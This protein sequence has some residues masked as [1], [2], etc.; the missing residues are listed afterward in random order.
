MT[1]WNKLISQA[2]ENQK[3]TPLAKANASGYG[4][5]KEYNAAGGESAPQKEPIVTRGDIA[6]QQQAQQPEAPSDTLIVKADTT[7]EISN[8]QAA[9]IKNIAESKS[10]PS[11][12][13]T[14]NYLSPQPE[15]KLS[16]LDKAGNWY[17]EKIVKP[18]STIYL[19]KKA[20]QEINTYEEK[21]QAY[22]EQN[23][24]IKIAV[25]NYIS[26]QFTKEYVGALESG[27]TK[28]AAD[29]KNFYEGKGYELTVQKQGDTTYFS[30]INP[31][32]DREIASYS[33]LR[34]PEEIKYSAG[35]LRVGLATFTGS[36]VSIPLL[37][38]PKGQQEF[39]PGIVE[40]VYN[41]PKGIYEAG[42]QRSYGKLAIVGAEVGGTVAAAFFLGEAFN[43]GGSS[44]RYG[45][46]RMGL[47]DVKV[48]KINALSYSKE[49]P[50]P[51]ADVRM[52]KGNIAAE[53]SIKNL[54]GGTKK[55]YVS[56]ENIGFVSRDLIPTNLLGEIPAYEGF[57]PKGLSEAYKVD[58]LSKVKY[59]KV[60]GVGL[61]EGLS[62]DLSNF[63]RENFYYSTGKASIKTGKNILTRELTP[64]EVNLGLTKENI[65]D[66]GIS[67]DIP[68]PELIKNV[69]GVKAQNF[70]YRELSQNIGEPV[71]LGRFNRISTATIGET[72]NQK[73]NPVSYER[74]LGITDVLKDQ[75]IFNIYYSETKQLNNVN[76]ITPNFNVQEK[77]IKET[78]LKDIKANANLNI[79]NTRAG[80]I[81]K[82]SSVK[83]NYEGIYQELNIKG[84][85]SL[86]LSIQDNIVRSEKLQTRFNLI[87]LSRDKDLSLGTFRPINMNLIQEERSLLLGKQTDIFKQIQMETLRP[88]L[89]NLAR[90]PNIFKV[91]TALTGSFPLI[92]F[93]PDFNLGNIDL[94]G[95]SRKIKIVKV[96]GYTPDYS[97]LIKGIVGKA[98]KSTITG[99]EFRPITKGFSFN[100][101]RIKVLK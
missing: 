29:I 61:S 11:D 88:Q 3:N 100:K 99:F 87:E 20:Q 40:T 71:N 54:I 4:T 52:F 39:F 62:Y 30:S 77:L 56:V 1:D 85:P 53:V 35:P 78:V 34:T 80:N 70:Y 79:E 36:V 25:T 47:V 18:L 63:G 93:I 65:K 73:L 5:V 81:V 33:N 95:I 101:L 92:P 66:Y 46:E 82:V 75:E 9:Y 51:S 90:T 68:Y 17:N 55:S 49:I 76:K 32:M 48:S 22:E 97:A 43:F 64:A 57:I 41:V 16:L 84:V 59:G 12:T 60:E 44:L 58:T 50:P 14:I 21:S 8:Q 23:I 38:T 37:L 13:S 96:V 86:S 42:Q 28:E 10:Y 2:K 45:A 31:A 15:Q 94:G 24:P 67:L 6:A 7:S 89:I 26:N 98:P 69:K 27:N 74:S 72:F 19:G 83:Y 91:P